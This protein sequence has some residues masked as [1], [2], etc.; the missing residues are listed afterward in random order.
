VA[1]SAG[2]TIADKDQEQANIWSIR[3]TGTMAHGVRVE[4]VTVRDTAGAQSVECHRGRHRAAAHDIPGFPS[5]A[6]PR[7]RIGRRALTPAHGHPCVAWRAPSI[8]SVSSPARSGLTDLGVGS[9]RQDPPQEA[10]SRRAIDRAYETRHCGSSAGWRSQTRT[11]KCRCR[12]SS[13]TLPGLRVARSRTSLQGVTLS[14]QT[15][16]RR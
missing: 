9:T 1:T 13:P 14:L 11:A 16:F 7:S 8:V 15:S 10:G 4:Y 2:R 12:A 6:D 5:C 3:A